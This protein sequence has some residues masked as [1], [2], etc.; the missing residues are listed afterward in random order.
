M[1]RPT[2]SIGGPTRPEL[3]I[4]QPSAVRAMLTCSLPIGTLRT[5][6]VR[7]AVPASAGLG[8]IGTCPIE[9]AGSATSDARERV[10]SNATQTSAMH[11]HGRDQ[12]LE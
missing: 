10:G 2:T 9:E 5:K 3:V 6:I 11:H 1:R 7:L 4:V 8:M 12:R